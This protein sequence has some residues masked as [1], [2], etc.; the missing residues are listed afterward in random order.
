M[1]PQSAGF[2]ATL[3]KMRQAE[4][5]AEFVRNHMIRQARAAQ[6]SGS[7]RWCAV[8]LQPLRTRLGVLGHARTARPTTVAVGE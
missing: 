5:R 8:L 7:P 3:G 2:N 4:I 6:P 1:F